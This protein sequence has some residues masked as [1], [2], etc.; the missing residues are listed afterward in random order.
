MGHRRI[1]LG[2][3][4]TD[5]PRDDEGLAPIGWSDLARDE[6]GVLGA[7]LESS[8]QATLARRRTISPLFGF[9]TSFG[10]PGGAAL[11]SGGPE[12]WPNRSPTRGCS[13]ELRRMADSSGTTAMVSGMLP[14]RFRFRDRRSMSDD[15]FFLPGTITCTELASWGELDSPFSSR[16]CR[17]G[18]IAVRRPPPLFRFASPSGVDCVRTKDP[19]WGR[20]DLTLFSYSVLF[21]RSF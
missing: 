18:S 6:V 13:S 20:E 15:D 2:V 16:L 9:P 7:H 8:L 14:E 11:A 5:P 21:F 1:K 19:R 12:S 17:S 3:G 10:R 4:V